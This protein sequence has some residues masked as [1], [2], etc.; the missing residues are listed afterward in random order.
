MNLDT[1]AFIADPVN[2][3]L[4]EFFPALVEFD[5]VALTVA[6]IAVTV[7]FVLLILVVKFFA[8]LLSLIKRFILFIIVL[9]S[10]VA[11]FLRFQTELLAQPPD[12]TILA[13]G[14]IGVV[15]AIIA[16]AISLFS[17][18]HHWGEAKSKR[19]G[20]IRQDMREV[21]EKEVVAELKKNLKVQAT[22]AITPTQVQQ[23]AM[24]SKQ[25]LLPKNLLQSFNDRSLLAVLSYMVV[26][27]FGVFSGV[28]IGAPN[29]MVG[30]IFFGLF[31]VAA[32]VFIKTT[33]HN[34]L[35]GLRHLI[36]ALV[37]GFALSVVLGHV[38]ATIPLAE[39]LSTAYFTS[40]S[41]VAL[42]TGLAISLFMGSKG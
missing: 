13:V 20:E 39:L 14:A 22:P 10:L 21:V 2:Y 37:F 40:N 42:V 4:G 36:I 38:W 7:F 16:F 3:M 12:Y 11:F 32:F 15:F 18:K 31:L 17:L 35:T 19:L 34:Y 30:M 25:V 29:Q 24:L 27:Q 5:P 1:S 26:A 6:G 33:Y 9:G 23:P 8:W 28:T 41:L